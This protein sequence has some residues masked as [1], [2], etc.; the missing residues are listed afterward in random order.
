MMTVEH[1][2][3]ANF[4]TEYGNFEIHAF[5]AEGEQDILI[6]TMGDVTRK[7]L[8]VRIHS[9]CMTGDIFHSK[10]CDC[11]QQ[12]ATS[13]E[14]IN[15]EGSGMLVYLPSHEGRGIG[16]LNKIK[17]YDLQ[18]QGFDTVEANKK[19]GFDEDL[20]DYSFIADIFKY[21]KV[22]SVR[23]LTNNP[24]KIGGLDNSGIRIERVS[25]KTQTHEINEKYLKAKKD[26]L[27]HL[28]SDR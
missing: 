21:F 17:A 23:L 10:R 7:S 16:I 5:Q 14:R 19:L 15:D 8:L 18:D 25:L 4:P 2:A 12:L 24:K 22:K 20:R 28:L 13:L 9:G 3:S 6:L 27:G 26:K 1:I 11:R